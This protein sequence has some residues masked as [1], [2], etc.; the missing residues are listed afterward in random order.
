[1]ELDEEHVGSGGEGDEERVGGGG[2]E[3]VEEGG[4]G[5]GGGDLHRAHG[6]WEAGGGPECIP[7]LLHP[8]ANPIQRDKR[9]KD[10]KKTGTKALSRNKI[11]QIFSSS[12]LVALL[13]RQDLLMIRRVKYI[14]VLFPHIRHELHN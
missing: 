12:L 5:A 10:Q 9:E 2:G 1:M 6:A 3:G 4:D 13:G 7:A 11:I 14:W 8:W